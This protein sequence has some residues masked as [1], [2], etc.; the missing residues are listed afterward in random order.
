[1]DG[2]WEVKGLACNFKFQITKSV[3]R[4]V[5]VEY[6]STDQSVRVFDNQ[7]E[8]HHEVDMTNIRGTG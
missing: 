8:H 7:C 4:M 5:K 3:S 1:M 6:T 2:R